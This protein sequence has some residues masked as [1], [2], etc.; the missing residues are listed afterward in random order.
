MTH[1]LL[2]FFGDTSHRVDAFQSRS[3]VLSLLFCLQLHCCGIRWPISTKAHES[4]H[5]RNDETKTMAANEKKMTAKKK[6]NNTFTLPHNE[7]GRSLLNDTFGA[8]CMY[9]T[10]KNR[11]V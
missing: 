10:N 4:E 9:C 7:N 5:E 3:D 11:T 8:N 2:T 6:N 1:V